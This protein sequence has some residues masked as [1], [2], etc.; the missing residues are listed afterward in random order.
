M[1]TLFDNARPPWD[2]VTELEA[3]L[4]HLNRVLDA[5]EADLRRLES[6]ERQ[7]LVNL[8]AIQREN[9]ALRERAREKLARPMVRNTDGDTSREAEEGN[10]AIRREQIQKFV[11]VFHAAGDDG[12]TD[13]QAHDAVGLQSHTPRVAD[14]KRAGMLEPTGQRRATKSGA[15]ARVY[16]LV[17]EWKGQGYA[18]THTE[19]D[20]GTETST[21]SDPEPDEG[22]GD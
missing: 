19:A 17:K 3:R 21:G 1:P 6:M 18:Q 16:R 10:R 9:E 5:A 8:A 20:H 2:L 12:L 15:T 13:E 7:N 11:A 22:A 4:E 14:M